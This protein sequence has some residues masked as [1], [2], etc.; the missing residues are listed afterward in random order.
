MEPLHVF[1]AIENKAPWLSRAGTLDDA[2]VA[3]GERKCEKWL[4][5]Y[6]ECVKTGEWPGYPDANSNIITARLGKQ[7]NL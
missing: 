7:P 1:I 6:A 5:R 4:T 3:A 2:A